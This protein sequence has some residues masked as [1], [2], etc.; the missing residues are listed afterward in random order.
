MAK[1]FDLIVIGTGTAAAT[2]ANRCANAGWRV[3]MIDHLP[4]G[5]TCALRGC[6]PKKVLVGVAEALDLARRTRGKGL[7]GGDPSIDW[8]AMMAFKRTFTEHSRRAS[9]RAARGRGD[10]RL[11]A[12]DPSRHNSQRAPGRDLRVSNRRLGHRVH[13]VSVPSLDQISG[14]VS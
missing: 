14:P 3:A 9:G 13:A 1:A 8:R 11:R 2:A 6:D 10:Q 12:R 7:A 4:Y 5:G